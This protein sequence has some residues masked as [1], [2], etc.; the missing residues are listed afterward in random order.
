MSKDLKEIGFKNCTYYKKSWSK[1]NQ[2]RRKV[3]LKYFYPINN[4]DQ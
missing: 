2:D 4:N 3:L 1:Q